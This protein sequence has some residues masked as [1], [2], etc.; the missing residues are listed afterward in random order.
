MID[1]NFIRSLENAHGVDALK[2]YVPNSGKSGVTIAT[3]CDLGWITPRAMAQLPITLQAAL[4]PYIGAVGQVAEAVLAR[5][6]LTISEPDADAIDR[7]TFGDDTAAISSAYTRD[8]GTSF[9]SLPDRAQTVICSLAFQYGTNLARRTP[10]FW[11]FVCVRDWNETVD[12]LRHFGDA[13][14]TRH[15][16]EA[17][18]LAPLCGG[19]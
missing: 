15:N 7:V 2:G 6:P 10:R 11:H 8:S 14:D 18:Y 16:R 17:D 12:D 4:K 3:G 1:W 19:H 13:Y 9:L 5:A